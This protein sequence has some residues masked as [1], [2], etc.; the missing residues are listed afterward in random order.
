MPKKLEEIKDAIMKKDFVPRDGAS[1][2]EA[3]YAIATAKVKQ[4][5]DKKAAKA[6]KSTDDLRKMSKG[7][8]EE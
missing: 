6:P 3:A 7:I 8:M 4:M 2:E 5:K 1:K